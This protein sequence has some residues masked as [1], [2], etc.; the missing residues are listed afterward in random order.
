MFALTWIT[1]LLMRRTLRL[2]GT[3]AAVAMAVAM[4]GSLGVFF[5]ASTIANSLVDETEAR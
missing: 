2:V 5:A 1:G 4:F 3:A